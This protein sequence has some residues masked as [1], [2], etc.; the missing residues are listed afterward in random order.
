MSLPNRMMGGRSAERARLEARLGG[1]RAVHRQQLAA[2]TRITCAM[3]E[4][5]RG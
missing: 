5:S 2:C 1:M 3:R 4:A